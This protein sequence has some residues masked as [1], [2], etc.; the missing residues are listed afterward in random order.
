MLYIVATPIGNLKDISQRAIETLK[1]ADLIL[2]ED[3]RSAGKILQILGIT[4]KRVTSFFEHNEEQKIQSI[5]EFLKMDKSVALISDGGTPLISDP[6]YKLVRECHK[7]KI[8]VVPIPGASAVVT[9]LCASG[10]PSDKFTFIGFLPKSSGKQATLLKNL[11]ELQDSIKTS[12]I[13]YE[14]PYRLVKTLNEIKN[15]FGDITVCVA[16]EMTKLFENITTDK[17]DI[18]IS[19]YSTKSP[20]GEFTIIL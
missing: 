4:D 1:Q 2:A 17:I 10:M 14:S 8:Q 19:K 5:I 11:K 7:E 12:I 20:K 13:I 3:T 16:C 9:A 6:G 15:I 18:L